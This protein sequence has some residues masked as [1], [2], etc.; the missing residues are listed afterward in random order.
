MQ[1]L[2]NIIAEKINEIKNK[3]QLIIPAKNTDTLS[4]EDLRRLCGSFFKF[5]LENID[6]STL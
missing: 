6:I 2:A 1:V 5:S 3:V 4:Y